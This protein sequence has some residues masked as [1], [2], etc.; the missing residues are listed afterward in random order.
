M[1]RL[2]LVMAALIVAM[3]VPHAEQAAAKPEATSL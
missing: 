2:A 3:A 1:K